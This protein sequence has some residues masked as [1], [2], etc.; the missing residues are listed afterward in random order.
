MHFVHEDS[1]YNTIVPVNFV[2][3]FPFLYN[4]MIKNSTEHN[5]ELFLFY[6]SISLR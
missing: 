5:P 3:K 1:K 2:T 4:Q 6:I